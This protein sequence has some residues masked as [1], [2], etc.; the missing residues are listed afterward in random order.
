VAKK[1]KPQSTQTSVEAEQWART[2][3]EW[4]NGFRPLVSNRSTAEVA[5]LTEEARKRGWLPQD[6]VNKPKRQEDEDGPQ[7]ARAKLALPK[8]KT[9]APN[10][11][12]PGTRSHAPSTAAAD[13]PTCAIAHA[14]R[15][16]NFVRDSIAL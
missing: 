5:L 16:R 1:A 4:L 8:V 11:L 7:V 3:W 2:R 12:C 9:C 15:M 6:E 13:R 10:G 14:Q